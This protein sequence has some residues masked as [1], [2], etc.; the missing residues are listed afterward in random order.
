[1]HAPFQSRRKSTCGWDFPTST[2]G[3]QNTGQLIALGRDAAMGGTP[4]GHP[5]NIALPR[6]WHEAEPERST[7]RGTVHPSPNRQEH[8]R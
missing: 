3:Y 7:R 4:A 5:A 8:R 1:M 6:C 2:Q